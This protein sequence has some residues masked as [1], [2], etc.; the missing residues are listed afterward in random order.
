[1]RMKS[2]SIIETSDAAR[3]AKRLFNHWKHKFEVS[4]QDNI[5][6]IFMPTATVTLQAAPTYL[7]VSID[8]LLDDL[9]P[10]QQVVVRH[11]NRMANTELTAIWQ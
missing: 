5:T 11:L 10:L 3:I 2:N 4:E 1:M 6:R 7:K 8:S 9:A